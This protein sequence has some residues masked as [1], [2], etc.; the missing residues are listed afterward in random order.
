[1]HWNLLNSIDPFSMWQEINEELEDGYLSEV[2]D[3]LKLEQETYRFQ[4]S[5]E[6]YLNETNAFNGPKTKK[7]SNEKVFSDYVDWCRAAE[8]R[9][10]TKQYFG[11]RLKS[12][13]FEQDRAANERSYFY[14]EGFILWGQRHALKVQD[15]FL[16]QADK[17]LADET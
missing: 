16:E 17:L 10:L 6:N 7:V 12:L 14:A 8:E 5:I 3:L 9:P 15:D 4:D 11:K 1:M 2:A 13:G